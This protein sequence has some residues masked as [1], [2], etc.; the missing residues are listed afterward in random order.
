MAPLIFNSRKM[1]E[2]CLKSKATL[3]FQTIQHSVTYI[4]PF[5]V[6]YKFRMSVMFSEG[7]QRHPW[8]DIEVRA[9]LNIW[10]QDKFIKGCWEKE[11][12]SVVANDM[13]NVG[14]Y[15]DQSECR[16]K[17]NLL[18]DEYQYART[19]STTEQR[20]NVF[21]FYEK[22]DTIMKRRETARQDISMKPGDSGIS[23][24]SGY[25]SSDTASHT[26]PKSKKY[27]YIL[28]FKNEK[29]SKL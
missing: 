23:M 10:S 22:M 18:K 12:F 21:K 13:R 6:E 5:F 4:M 25:I 9:L 16:V 3:H 8:S 2:F 14:F 27:I 26:H 1:I 7:P 19:L 29:G 24:V 20:R 15:R 17:I 28:V 11:I